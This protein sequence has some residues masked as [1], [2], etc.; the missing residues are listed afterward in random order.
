MPVRTLNESVGSVSSFSVSVFKDC[1]GINHTIS[2]TSSGNAMPAHTIKLGVAAQSLKK[3]ITS[4]TIPK[5]HT[6][7]VPLPT[8]K[9][10]PS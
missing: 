1:L 10:K 3:Q 7:T 2:K 9:T 8:P 5:A 4:P 6:A